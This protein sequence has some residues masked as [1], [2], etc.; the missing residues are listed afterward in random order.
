M[1]PS[2][3]CQPPKNATKK[4][5]KKEEWQVERKTKRQRCES[6]MTH[7]YTR[8]RKAGPK[9]QDASLGQKEAENRQNWVTE[10]Y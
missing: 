5:N 8:G 3:V 7:T 6:E 10:D 2:V 4:K 1:H 9:V